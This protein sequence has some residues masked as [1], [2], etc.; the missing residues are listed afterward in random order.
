M[1]PAALFTCSLSA[2]IGFSALA[3]AQP[4]TISP[5][6]QILR[7]CSETY[8]SLREFKGGASVI[9]LSSIEIDQEAPTNLL[10]SADAQF[11]FVRDGRF[12]ISGHDTEHDPFNITSTPQKTTTTYPTDNKG[13]PKDVEDVEM[14]VAGFTGVAATA[15]TTV[16]ALL[17][18]SGWGSPFS[19]KTDAT[20]KGSE[21]FGGHECYVIVQKER[22]APQTNTLWID[23]KTFLLRGMR[24]EQGSTSFAIGDATETGAPAAGPPAG[25]EQKLAKVLFSNQ[26][27]IFSIESTVPGE[28]ELET[29]AKKDIDA[30]ALATATKAN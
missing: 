21:M 27:H 19:L 29:A 20:L 12:N 14:A 15:P 23:S 9:S 16:P 24:E 11:D 6:R 8:K 3:Q 13:L 7:A 5:G 26:M 4:E 17:L 25:Q 10:R 22:G 28:A 1:K 18:D 2:L 30:A